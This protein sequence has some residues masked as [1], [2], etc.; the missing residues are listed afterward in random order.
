MTENITCRNNAGHLDDVFEIGV[1]TPYEQVK[2]R[3][4]DLKMVDSTNK[5]SHN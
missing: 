1:F 2:G 3:N 5:L 4:S